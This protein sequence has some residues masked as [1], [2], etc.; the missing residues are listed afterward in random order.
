MTVSPLSIHNTLCANGGG[1]YR[2]GK[3]YFTSYYEDMTGRAGI[4]LFHRDGSLTD[5]S[6][7]RHA[8][9]PD[10]YQ[11]IAADMTYDPVGTTRSTESPFNPDDLTLTSYILV[12]YDI[13]TG[14]PV[15]I[16]SIARMSALA[17][18]TTWGQ[19]WGVR[20]SD[21]KL[22]KINKMNAEVT[23][24]G[25]T[26]VNPIY[27]G[28]ACFDFETGKLYW[29]TNERGTQLS[30]LY[31]IDTTTGAASLI[32]RSIPTTNRCPLCICPGADNITL[33]GSP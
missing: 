6:I 17:R 15:T 4:S 14:Y 23:E 32:S 8:L 2:K 12:D 21:G 30:G 22:V 18:A 26:G 20:Y 31:Q 29:S 24:V 13:E 10:T 16:G 27:N 19:L 3:L 5:Y 33:L 9:R 11:A 1:T 25:A 28:T 7:E